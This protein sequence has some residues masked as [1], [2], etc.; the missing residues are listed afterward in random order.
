MSE[1]NLIG[2]VGYIGRYDR[3]RHTLPV[4]VD[5]RNEATG[6]VV[7]TRWIDLCDEIPSPWNNSLGGRLLRGEGEPVNPEDIA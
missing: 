7:A 6:T 1:I 3:D 4:R 5:V 2:E